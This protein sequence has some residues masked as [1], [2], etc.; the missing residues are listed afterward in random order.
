MA[1]SP[2][3][4]RCCVRCF[5]APDSEAVQLRAGG[6]RGLGTEG[7]ERKPP[8]LPLTH[9]GECPWEG[10]GMGSASGRCPPHTLPGTRTPDAKCCC[11]CC[12]AEHHHHHRLAG[13]MFGPRSARVRLGSVSHQGCTNDLPSPLRNPE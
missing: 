12:D 9:S 4:A 6:G 11:D 5:K 10:G 3:L 8:T 7:W 13:C 2:H 1:T